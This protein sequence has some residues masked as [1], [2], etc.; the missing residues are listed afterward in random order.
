LPVTNRL[1]ELDRVQ[2][3]AFDALR[4]ELAAAIRSAVDMQL[5]SDNRVSRIRLAGQCR[6][7]LTSFNEALGV[8]SSLDLIGAA[9][10]AHISALAD[11]VMD[12]VRDQIL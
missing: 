11:T 4:A 8:A 2:R 1:G 7:D 10:V 3:Q 5:S 6:D 9:D 12:A